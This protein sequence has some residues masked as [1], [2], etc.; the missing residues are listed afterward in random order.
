MCF[1]LPNHSNDVRWSVDLRWQ[2]PHE[3]WGFY[4]IAP[5]ILFR[6]KDNADLKPDWEKFLA[7]NRKEVWQQRYKVQVCIFM[8]YSTLSSVCLSLY[9]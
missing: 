6:S 4:D 8:R 5:G 9:M 7:I 3:K 2:S 1:S